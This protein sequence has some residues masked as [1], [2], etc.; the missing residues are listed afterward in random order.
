ME[1]A[2]MVVADLVCGCDAV[3]LVISDCWLFLLCCMV[4]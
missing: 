3:W 1:V 2:F 4:F